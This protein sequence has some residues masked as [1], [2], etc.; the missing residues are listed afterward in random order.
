MLDTGIPN[1]ADACGESKIERLDAAESRIA[2]RQAH[3]KPWPSNLTAEE[4]L[5][6]GKDQHVKEKQRNSIVAVCAIRE[7]PQRLSR[8]VVA[9]LP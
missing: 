6:R 2:S 7:H 9:R 8:D 5:E 4:L 1:E 3:A